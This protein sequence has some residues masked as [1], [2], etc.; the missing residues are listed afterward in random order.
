[1]NPV[2]VFFVVFFLAFQAIYI[3]IFTQ[4]ITGV[5][6]PLVVL[7]SAILAIISAY[8]EN[9]WRILGKKQKPD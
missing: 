7:I 6:V 3:Y 1:M 2:A 9:E 5:P 8:A 4:A